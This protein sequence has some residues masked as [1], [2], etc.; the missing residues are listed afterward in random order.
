MTTFDKRYRWVRWVLGPAI[1]VTAALNCA[2]ASPPVTNDI[3]SSTGS[4][5]APEHGVSDCATLLASAET[6]SQDAGAAGKLCNDQTLNLAQARAVL[7]QA[8]SHAEAKAMIPRLAKHQDLQGLARL[9][10]RDRTASALPAQLPPPQSAIVTPVSEE[11]LAATIFAYGALMRPGI[12]RDDRTRALAFLA[13]VNIQALQQ[14]GLGDAESLPAF[15]RLLAADALHYGRRFCTAYWQ[16]RVLGLERLF[17]DTEIRLLAIVHALEGSHHHADYGR[18]AV[19]RQLARRYV[20]RSGPRQRIESR[21]GHAAGND[22][23]RIQHVSQLAPLANELQRLMDQRFVDLAITRALHLGADSSGYG[24]DPVV[25]LLAETI[26]GRQLNEHDT[27]LRERIAEYRRREPPPPSLGPRKLAHATEPAWATA[28][29]IAGQVVDQVTQVANARDFSQRY[30]A[31]VLADLVR[32]RSDSIRQLAA[33][34]ETLDSEARSVLAALWQGVRFGDIRDLKT[35]FR[36]RSD[37]VPSDD[38][39]VRQMFAIAAIDAAA[40]S[41]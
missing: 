2:D 20:Q 17:A 36:L 12:P 27:L 13:K 32:R 24:I 19:E 38:A 37:T 18:L 8:T 6:D 21:I 22:N 41:S 14:L 7:L 9:V 40:D 11:V 39:G 31:A 35:L 15:A 30:H 29:E 4:A 34:P 25:E 10:A 1:L 3:D 16:N 5:V 26:A 23:V 28:A 33:N